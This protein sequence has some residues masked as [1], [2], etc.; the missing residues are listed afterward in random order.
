L[1]TI[2][3]NKDV[4]GSADRYLAIA[5]EVEVWDGIREFWAAALSSAA[6]KWMALEDETLSWEAYMLEVMDD[7]TF[8]V[9]LACYTRMCTLTYAAIPALNFRT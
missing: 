5:N 4:I 6:I 1:L 2:L 3:V 7:R 9:S 8:A